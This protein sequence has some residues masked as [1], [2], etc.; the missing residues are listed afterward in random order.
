MSSLILDTRNLHDLVRV[1]GW[2]RLISGSN[3]VAIYDLKTNK[4]TIL[5][6]RTGMCERDEVVSYSKL[7]MSLSQLAWLHSLSNARG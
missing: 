3:L 7:L 5:K 2:Q 1:A 4:Y 6:D